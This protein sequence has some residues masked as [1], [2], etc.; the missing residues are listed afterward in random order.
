M[1]DEASRFSESTALIA[2]HR[3]LWDAKPALRA[4]YTDYHRRLMEAMPHDV[5]GPVVDLGGGSGHLKDNFS[6][7]VV[8]DILNSPHVDVI[9]DAHRLPF[10]DSSLRG[11][12]MLDVLHHLERPVTFLREMGRVLRPGG[13]IAMIE[14]SM[15]PLA[16][17]FFNFIHQEPVDL[18]ADPLTD[19]AESDPDRDPFDSNQAIP[20]LIFSKGKGRDKYEAMFPNLRIADHS[21]LSLMA[22]PFSGGFKSWSLVPGPM[23]EPMLRFEEALLPVFGPFMA[24]RL[25]VVLEKT[26]EAVSD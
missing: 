12:V 24:F 18:T 14:P 11:V 2:Q 13:R 8:L 10:A 16:W 26:P 4:V 6:D 1:S 3:A 19:I 5:D 9:G 15:T 22:Y 17:V 7:V 23:A 20:W 21:L 25:M